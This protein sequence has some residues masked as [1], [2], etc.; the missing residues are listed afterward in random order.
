MYQSMP[1][2]NH[3]YIIFLPTTVGNS[4]ILNAMCGIL[5]IIFLCVVDNIR[6]RCA[7]F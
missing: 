5:C 6:I 4:P 2:R 1:D 7:N 3:K